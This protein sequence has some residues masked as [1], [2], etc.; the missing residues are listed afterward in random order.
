M[1]RPDEGAVADGNLRFEAPERDAEEVMLHGEMGEQLVAEKRAG[2]HPRRGTGAEVAP[3]A[4]TAPGA[5]SVED[6]ARSWRRDI[7]HGARLEAAL[8]ELHAAVRAGSLGHF[9]GYD[10][11]RLAL[12]RGAP[13]VSHVPGFGTAATGLSILERELGVGFEGD[14]RGGGGGAEGPF[15]TGDALLVAKPIAKKLD[16][17]LETI[18]LTLL[19]EALPAVSLPAHHRPALRLSSRCS[20]LSRASMR[21]DQGLGDLH[22]PLF[23]APPVLERTLQRRHQLA[24]HVQ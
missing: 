14:L 7:D 15:F 1:E 24:G 23:D 18:D 4:R 11:V 21:Q 5:E 2:Q 10:L 8:F 12:L 16:L 3:T 19:L 6:R 13:S 9:E 17:F 22:H 20:P